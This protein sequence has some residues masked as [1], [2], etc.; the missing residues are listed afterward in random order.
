MSDRERLI[1][2]TRRARPDIAVSVTWEPDPG[3]VWDG[4]G[5]EPDCEIAHNVTVT[6]R[7]IRNGELIEGNAYLGGSFSPPG[8]PHCPDVHGYFP[9]MLEEAIAELDAE[10]AR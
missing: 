6:A 10:L 8:G 2:E 1:E 3:F 7:A 4:D 9:Q 5:P